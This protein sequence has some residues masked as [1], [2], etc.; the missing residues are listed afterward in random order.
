MFYSGEY[1]FIEL[2]KN[3]ISAMHSKGSFDL[4]RH[5]FYL[6]LSVN[7]LKKKKKPF[8]EHY[9]SISLCLKKKKIKLFFIVPKFWNV[10]YI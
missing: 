8:I 4:L 6:S 9:K 7:L 1:F 5:K 10:A 2:F 3:F